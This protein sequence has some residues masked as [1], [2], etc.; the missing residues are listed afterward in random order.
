MSGSNST[1]F[2]RYREAT[3]HSGRR[4]EKRQ[5]YILTIGNLS[6]GLG[7]FLGLIPSTQTFDRVTIYCPGVAL[8]QELNQAVQLTFF[9]PLLLQGRILHRIYI[10]AGTTAGKIAGSCRAHFA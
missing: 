1:A 2:K 9:P 7:M 5:C 10:Q 4:L 6:A 8:L 3:Q